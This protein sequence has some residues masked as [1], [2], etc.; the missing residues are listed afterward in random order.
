[1]LVPAVAVGRR[2]PLLPGGSWCRLGARLV[3]REAPGPTR[4]ARPGRTAVSM[5]GALSKSS[6]AVLVRGDSAGDA[7]RI[8]TRNAHRS[9]ISDVD[10]VSLRLH[11]GYL[12]IQHARWPLDDAFL[13]L[14]W[15]RDHCRSRQCYNHTTFQ[16]QTDIR[17]L[18]S[19]A[20]PLH[21]N[22]D[23]TGTTLEII[24]QDGHQSEYSLQWLWENSYVGSR[25]RQL[26]QDRLWQRCLWDARSPL[27]PEDL[28]SVPREALMGGENGVRRLLKGFLTHGV[29]LVSGVTP[30]VEATQE[31][32]ERVGVV[33]C[34][35]FGGMWD[36]AADGE[37]ADTA[38]SRDELQPHTDGT[39]YSEPPGVQVFHCLRHDGA[40]GETTLVDGFAGLQRL[41][42]ADPAAYRLLST[43]P[44]AAEYRD[45]ARGLHLVGDGPVIAHQHTDS[46]PAPRHLLRLRF[47]PYD[48][49]PVRRGE[50]AQVEAFYRAYSRL[51]ELLWAERQ[52]RGLKLT[53][54]TVLLIDNWRV[55]HGRAAFSGQRHMCGAYIARSDVMSRARA[56][57]LLV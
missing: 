31:V 33:Q 34:T 20:K 27:A 24:W 52:R 10:T 57:G 21:F 53:P 40:G 29:A 42:D 4:L 49:A 43:V 39:Y 6:G 19:D 7:A 45:P 2:A 25:H 44:C 23:A 26:R 13:S 37:H 47:N 32:V 54:G 41:Y 1:M 15:L 9:V 22:V 50:P 38:Y 18:I 12:V 5:C 11:R 56:A 16:R 30:T 55:L 14:V 3:T 51:T 48:R 17:R 46:E 8:R 36:F 28:T 35:M